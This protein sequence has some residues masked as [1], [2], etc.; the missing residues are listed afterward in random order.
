M[1]RAAGSCMN[2][3]VTPC[4]DGAPKC[5]LIHPISQILG[6]E[7]CKL[8]PE[9]LMV[10]CAWG[11]LVERHELHKRTFASARCRGQLQLAQNQRNGK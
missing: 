1:V 3:M 8:L 10:C 7:L 5:M 6:C 4:W 11:V 9:K 2:W